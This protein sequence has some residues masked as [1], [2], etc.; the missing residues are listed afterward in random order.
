M[1]KKTSVRHA[2]TRD[3]EIDQRVRVRRL[4]RGVAQTTLGKHLG[5]S[6]Q[7]IQKYEN[8]VNR[9]GSGRL[10]RIAEF[11][12]VPV[13]FFFSDDTNSMPAKREDYES[14]L[15]QLSTEGAVRL[16]RAYSRIADHRLRYAVVQIV[17]QLA[18]DSTPRMRK[19]AK[20]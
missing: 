10:Q 13:G 16:V 19:N 6:F 3:K 12:D 20:K 7:Q 2:E 4:A 5:V 9:I 15:A 17:E 8:G 11:L 14:P 18:G 1:P